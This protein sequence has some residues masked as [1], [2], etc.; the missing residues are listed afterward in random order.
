MSTM[1]NDPVIDNQAMAASPASGPPDP[2]EGMN[3]GMSDR[4]WVAEQQQQ[5]AKAASA[6]PVDPGDTKRR[7]LTAALISGK[8]TDSERAA[9]S[10]ELRELIASQDTA[11]ERAAY[12]DMTLAEFRRAYD[13]PPPELPGPYAAVYE[14]VYAPVERQLYVEGRAAG[15]PSSVLRELRDEAVRLG[16]EYDGRPVEDAVLDRALARHGEKLTS[17]QRDSLKAWWRANVEG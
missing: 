7:E 6:A 16:M 11:V 14:E 1:S 8:L 10:R 13:V 12:E 4:A 17:K 15:V 3:L 2:Y 5:Q 9:K